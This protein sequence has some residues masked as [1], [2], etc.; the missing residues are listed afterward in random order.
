MLKTFKNAGLLAVLLLFVPICMMAQRTV[1]GVVK[2]ASGAIPGVTVAVKGS[3][4]A[5]VTDIGG[6]YKLTV[7]QSAKVLVFSFI[8]Y[9]PTEM[10]IGNKAVINVTMHQ[11]TTTLNEVVAIGYGTVKKRDLTG[12]VASIKSQDIVLAP[13]AN[14]ME[15]LQ[16]RIAGL[17][18]TKTSGKIGSDVTILLRG[19]RSIYGSN[20]PLFIIDGVQ[21]ADYN[22]LNPS[23]I[24]TIDVLKDASSTAI[25]GSAGANGVVIITTKRGKEGK[26][27]VNF[28]AYYGFSGKVDYKHGM[29]GDEWTA[30]QKEAYTYINGVAPTDMSAILT[31]NDYLAAYNANKWIDWVDQAS[32]NTATTQKYGLSVTSGTEHSHLFASTSYQRE[33][34]LLDDDNRNMYQIRLNLEEQVLPILKLGFNSNLQYQDKN[35][36]DNKTFTNSISAFPLGDAYTENGDI[37]Y[38]Y[39]ANHY[40]PLGDMIANQYENNTRQ[41]NISA[42]GYAELTPIKGLSFKSQVSIWLSHARLGQYWGAEANANI[43][44]YAGTPSAQVSNTDYYAYSWDNVLS[45]NTTIASDHNLGLTV[46][47]SWKKSTEEFN[48]EEGSGQAVDSW[49]YHRLMSATGRYL[50]SDYYQTQQLGF[51]ARLNYSYKGRYLLNLS[52]RWDGVSWLAQGHKWASFPA[53]AAAWRISDEPFMK[54]TKGWLDNLKLRVGYG[55]T[56]NSGGMSPYQTSP[57]TYWYTS[58]GVT[59]NGN[60]ASF[61]QYTGTFSGADLT[62]EKSHNWNVGLD[63]AVLGNRIDGSIEWFHTTTDGLLFKRTLPAT[64][65]LTGWGSPLSSWQ[66]IAKTENKGIELTINSRN[67]QSSDFTWNTSFT[68][69]WEKEKIDHLLNGDL[70]SENLFEGQ[71][72]KSF[73]SYKYEGIWGTDEATEAALYGCKPGFIK[74]QTVA[75]STDAVAGEH[76]YSTKD[77]QVV[78]HNNPNFIFGL[79]NTFTY[80]NFDLSVFAMARFGQTICSDLIGRYTAKYSVTENQISGVDYWTESNQGAYF[81]RPGTGG[82]QSVVYSCLSYQDGSFIK[83]KNITIGYTLPKQLTEVA[84]MSKV[85]FYFTAYNPAIWV[86]SKQLRGTDPETNGSDAFPL[87]RQY[88]FG[89]NVTF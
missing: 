49:T 76:S 56:G 22:S 31:N 20:S 32:G 50:N 43:P 7:P 41:T 14:A 62:W 52:N 85:R 65:A 82:D 15:A 61:A 51:A 17:D 69:S 68:M 63:F 37:N 53:A 28:D 9:E 12:S 39:I 29:T 6:K 8:G 34:G 78:G 47:S 40:T 44:T 67:I 16:G 24:E 84:W 45:Y 66:N 46:A 88:V 59:V 48:L 79:N 21:G 54:S 36:G 3:S 81:P 87:Y 60:I 71:P 5:T 27:V 77:R 80:K 10:L 38:E 83:L 72:I 23:D 57:Q 35:S 75:Q 89:V 26:P 64:S 73:Y 13:T 70:I 74:I 55:I 2:D 11:S 19:S 33:T 4:A 30:Y 1:Q 42:I 18:I 86:K 25:Y 58:S